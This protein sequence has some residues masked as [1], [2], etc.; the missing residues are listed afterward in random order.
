MA[1]GSGL[2]EDSHPTSVGCS[3]Q[4]VPWATVLGE[5]TAARGGAS[6]LGLRGG[7]TA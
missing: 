3:Q 1:P 5:E 4:G 7:F 2:Q 6:G